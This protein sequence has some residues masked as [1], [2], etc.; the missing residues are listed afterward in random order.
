MTS[1]AG[2]SLDF[3]CHIGQAFGDCPERR[4][5]FDLERA[6]CRPPAPLCKLP[7]TRRI[8]WDRHDGRFR[9]AEWRV[10]QFV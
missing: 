1:S 7:K 9:I 5:R 2:T 6:P 4:Y 8:I 10:R 3:L